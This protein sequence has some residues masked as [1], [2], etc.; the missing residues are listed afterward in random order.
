MDR[1]IMF[2]H[3]IENIGLFTRPTTQG[4]E[5]EL[6]KDFIDYYIHVFLK[7]NKMNNLAVF[8]EPKV[9][10]GFPDI[11][12][13]SY[14]PKILDSWSDEREKLT[15]NDLKVMSHLIMTGGSTGNDLIAG[16]KMSEKITLQSIEN[17]LDANMICRIHGLWK[18]VDMRK[19]YNIKK[20]VSIE[21]KMTDMKKVAEQSLI[22]TWFASQ[23]YALTNSA[24][25]QTGTIRNFERQGIGL[26]CKKKGF[27]KIVEAKKLS[28]PSSYQSL[29]FNE[30]I[31]KTVAHLC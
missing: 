11:V 19:I 21:A 1:V 4:E 28:L 20:L 12:F 8:I 29:Q 17:L 6:V 30:W 18:P 10:S 15:V 27:K 9:A 2:N 24:N 23:S 5:L 13:A 14:T 3:N 25:P 22:N 31:G 7:N 16:L 26:Y